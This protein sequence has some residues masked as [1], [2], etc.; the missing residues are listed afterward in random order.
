MSPMR[1]ELKVQTRREFLGSAAVGLAALG[2]EPLAFAKETDRPLGVQLYTVRSLVGNDFPGTLR[3][4]RK[5]GYRNVETY[6]AEYKMSAK[7]LRA[8]IVDAGLTVPSAHFGYNDFDSRFEFAKEL[9]AECVVCSMVPLTIANSADGYKRGAEQYNVWGAKAKSMGLRFGFHNHNVEFHEFGGITG[10][11]ILLENTDP[12]LV[13]WQMDCYW[14][15]Q[16]GRD[17]VAMIRKYG[18]RIQSF[19]VKDRKPGAPVTLETGPDSA[20]FTE[21]GDGTLDWKS[22]LRL[23]NQDHVPYLFVEQDQTNRPPLESLQI[24][25][26]NLVKLLSEV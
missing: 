3:A 14:V 1:G 2:M 25:Y 26:T 13:Q 20:Y 12:S 8:A 18:H 9:G 15:A 16:A 5:I 11:E 17:P 21:V 7:E 4:I 24:S 6:V 10:L 23:A 19:H 22:I